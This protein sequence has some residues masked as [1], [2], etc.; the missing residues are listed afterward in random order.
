M[1][2]GVSWCCR[3]MT[4]CRSFV[5]EY[6][7]VAPGQVVDEFSFVVENR[8]VQDDFFSIDVQG[9]RAGGARFGLLTL[10]G[11]RSALC[12]GGECAARSNCEGHCAEMAPASS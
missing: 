12:T 4:V 10:H 9:I 11:R 3:E 1:E 5:F 2:T 6:L 7:E 8:A